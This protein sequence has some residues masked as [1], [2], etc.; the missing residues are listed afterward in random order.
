MIDW[1]WSHGGVSAFMI[2]RAVLAFYGTTEG[3]L[4]HRAVQHDG[5]ISVRA[6]LARRADTALGLPSHRICPRLACNLIVEARLRIRAGGAS[7][8]PCAAGAHRV[9]ILAQATLHYVLAL[10]V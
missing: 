8:T 6:I 5:L 3:D 9:H 4:P 10:L 2:L 1:A 7:R